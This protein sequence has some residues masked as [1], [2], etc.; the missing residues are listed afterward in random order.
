MSEGQLPCPPWLRALFDQQNAQMRDTIE[1]RGWAVEYVLG[2]DDSPAFGYTVGLWR[3]RHPE[4]V[5]FGYDCSTTHGLLDRLARQVCD[6]ARLQAG[7]DLELAGQPLQL[8]DIPNP[9]EVILG[10]WSFFRDVVPALQVVHADPAGR[11]PWE[12]GCTLRGRQ[13]MPGGFVA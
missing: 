2:E 8:F 6:G 13:P 5:S 9:H 4:L 11:W 3:L 12:P 7:Q 10:S 1:R